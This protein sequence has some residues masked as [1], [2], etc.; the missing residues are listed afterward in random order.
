MPLPRTPSQ[1]ARTLGGLLL[2][3]LLLGQAPSRAADRVFV[4]GANGVAI[5]LQRETQ[6]LWTP[7]VEA[8]APSSLSARRRV[9]APPVTV[10]L[11]ADQSPVRSQG[12]RDTCGTFA[13]VA[14]LEAAYKRSHGLNL[15][16]SEQYLNHWGQIFAGAGSGSRK[17]PNNETPAGSIGGGG[18]GRPLTAMA[19][20][21]SVPLESTLPY[22]SDGAYEDVNAGDSPSLN[23]WARAYTQRAIDDFNLAETEQRVVY[24]PPAAQQLTVMPQAALNA[25]RYRA[26]SIHFFSDSEVARASAYMAVLAQGRE[27]MV[28][29]RC[30][31]GQPGQGS[32]TPWTLPAGST[33]G[34]AGHAVLIV[35]YD[36]RAQRFRI[37]NSWGSEWADGGYAWISY[38]FI[39]RAAYAA[40]WIESVL[41]PD[42]PFNHD[43]HPQLALGRWQ[44]N[45]DGWKGLLDIYNL[46]VAAAG[47]RVQNRRLGTLFMADGRTFRVNG[48]LKGQALS[49]WVDWKRPDLPADAL[50]GARFDTWLF[51]R[52]VRGMAGRLREGQGPVYAVEAVK[53][54]APVTGRARDGGLSPASYLGRWDFRHDGWPGRLEI[55]SAAAGA[56]QLRGRYVDA[57]GRSFPLN[58]TVQ[59]DARLFR[60]T[61]GFATPQDFEGQLNGHE[62]GVMGGTTVWGG[63]TFGFYGSRRP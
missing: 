21:L 37:K 58:G 41:P 55:E 28:E 62:R 7:P 61:I 15:D 11:Q 24:A 34:S 43:N 48:E 52:D 54:D 27:V 49:F 6:R 57:Q 46:P 8:A 63:R 18:I 26:T 29:M 4:Q 17:L 45:F 2:A 56:G 60:F 53:G 14:A 47:G 12:G 20:G 51:S 19:R 32:T 10:D 13:T 31:D 42:L 30:C 44:L 1:A 25:A 33:G 9:V 59:P 22:I 50:T 39:E 40:A 36:D 16:L 38:E 5:P 3:T 23:D 35:G